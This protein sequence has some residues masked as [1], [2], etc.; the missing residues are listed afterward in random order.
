VTQ[1]QA[2]AQPQPQ[3]KVREIA[4]RLGFRPTKMLGQNFVIDPNTV[5]RVVRTAGIT[6][7]DV[8]VEVG[9]GIGSLTLGLL[10]VAHAVIAVEIDP[11]LP[12]SC[13]QRWPGTRRRTP[14]G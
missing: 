13:R 14:R 7:D 4:T 3:P 12:A 1:P 10:P 9:P 6:S 11:C 5:R 8:V 2:Q